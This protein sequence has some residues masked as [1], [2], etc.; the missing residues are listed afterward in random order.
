V[1][2]NPTLQGLNASVEVDGL[3]ADDAARAFLEENGF[4]N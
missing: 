3:S 4:L 1:F 2:D